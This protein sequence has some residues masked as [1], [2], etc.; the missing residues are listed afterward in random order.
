[1]N[2]LVKLRITLV[3]RL[4]AVLNIF[5]VAVASA[6]EKFTPPEYTIHRASKPPTIDGRLDDAV[7]KSAGVI[8]DFVFPWHV[9]GAKEPS[10]VRLLWDD[11]CLYIGHVCTDA[12][13]TAVH[14]E[15]DGKIPEDDC[16]E[17]MLM[18]N[19]ATPEK[20]YNLE[21]NVIG[22]IL[23]NHRPNGPDKP[24]AEKWDAE[25]LRFAGSHVGTLNDDSDADESWTVEIAIPWK[26][27][28][29]HLAHFPPKPGDELRGNF[30][31]HGGKTNPQY[32][33][34]SH[35]GTPKPQFHTPG[36][37][38]KFTLAE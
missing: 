16:F 20:Y 25:G 12:H 21:W 32:S 38:G 7:W 14:T 18:P 17:I 22:G 31:R 26:N 23:D 6:D 37:F 30:N 15:R 29:P 9:S 24:R 2:P 19:P 33:Q 8:D 11:D 27:F 34:W 10:V 3:R 35:G 13:I 1:M 4:V 36:R 5:L 28:E